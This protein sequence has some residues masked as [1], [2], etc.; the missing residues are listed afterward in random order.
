[1]RISTIIL[2]IH[3]FCAALLLAEDIKAQTVSIDA[4][5]VPVIQIF[6]T[7]EEQAGV[8]F[9]YNENTI[10][11]LPAISL[12]VKS[13]SLSAVLKEIEQITSLKFKQSGNL[14]GVSKAAVVKKTLLSLHLFHPIAQFCLK[15]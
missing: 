13:K 5:Q 4:K 3:L 6:K 10:Q 9:T 2:G 14:I 12:K 1:M 15:M 11:G 7:I 8:T